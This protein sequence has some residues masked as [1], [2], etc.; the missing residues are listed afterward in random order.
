MA[1][2]GQNSRE[3]LVNAATLLFRRNGYVATTVDQICEEAGVTKGAFFHHFDSKEAL[4][5]A[6]L[7]Q[8]DAMG[9]ALEA[10]APF[11]SE[12][13]PVAKVVGCMEFFIRL[14][15]SP[16]LLKSCLAGTTLQE[17]SESH[18]EIRCAA[19]DCFVHAGERFQKLLEEAARSRKKKL[20]TAALA[21][22][23][24]AAI[25]GSL[26]LYKGSRDEEVIPRNLN[27]VKAYIQ[28]LLD[29]S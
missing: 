14:F 17:V 10:D 23:W 7:E 5:V 27:H 4:A 18:P 16:G 12:T 21:S 26:L 1:K 2:R 25:Q 24:M 9:A 8:W 6:T 28:G 29:A 3:K 19:N 15:S 13:D 20:D 22:L 11:Q